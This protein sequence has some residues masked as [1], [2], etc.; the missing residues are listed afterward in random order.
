MH[1][2]IGF[3]LSMKTNSVSS[4]CCPLLTSWDCGQGHP[5]SWKWP[6]LKI[7]DPLYPL[8]VTLC[9]L[10]FLLGSNL[11]SA[12]LSGAFSSSFVGVAFSPVFLQI[13]VVRCIRSP[14]AHT[15]RVATFPNHS[16]CWAGISLSWGLAAT[17]RS[18]SR[19]GMQLPS[20]T[21]VGAAIWLQLLSQLIR[22]LEEATPSLTV[23][24]CLGEEAGKADGC[25]GTFHLP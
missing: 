1:R 9:A 5:W 15:G 18:S 7:E 24:I 20:H 19:P 11:M 13:P 12:G 23:N 10:P 22:E 4:P 17:V 21:D 6:I 25:P 8:M 3:W 16:A 14:G 2:F